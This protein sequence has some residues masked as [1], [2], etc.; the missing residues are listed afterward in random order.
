[1]YLKK[2]GGGAAVAKSGQAYAIAVF[3]TSKKMQVT[4]AG[5]TTEQNQNPGD[6]NRGVE[7]LQEFLLANNL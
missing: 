3:S 7:K 5:K 4:H 6:C 1:M 2:N